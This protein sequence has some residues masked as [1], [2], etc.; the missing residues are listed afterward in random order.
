MRVVLDTNVLVSALLVP[1]SAPA[2]LLHGFR[3]NRWE[4]LVSGVILEEYAEVLHR[5]RFGLKLDLIHSLLEEIRGRSVDVVPGK[6]YH[7]VHRD[8]ED[9]E[10][11]DVAI[12]GG[13]TVLVSGDHDLLSVREFKGVKIL[14]PAQF[15]HTYESP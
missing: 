15:L 12:A 7:A 11:L 8:P 14:S 3:D 9:N 1:R 10:F 13:A 4:L 2:T 5:P 6:R